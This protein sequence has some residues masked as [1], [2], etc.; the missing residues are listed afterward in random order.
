MIICPC[1]PVY[2]NA[3][4]VTLYEAQLPKNAVQEWI[5]DKLTKWTVDKRTN[6]L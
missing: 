5:T 3:V 2:C 6:S 1:N 4:C